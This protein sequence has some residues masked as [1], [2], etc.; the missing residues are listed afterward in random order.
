MLYFTKKK[1]NIS[2]KNNLVEN[3]FVSTRELM[4]GVN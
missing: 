4:V 2:I 1:R 3:R